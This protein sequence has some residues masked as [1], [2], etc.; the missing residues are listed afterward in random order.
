MKAQM[1]QTL[2]GTRP[3]KVGLAHPQV[4]SNAAHPVISACSNLPPSASPLL[5]HPLIN[6]NPA[7]STNFRLWKVVAK[8]LGGARTRFPPSSGAL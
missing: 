1:G 6:T 2:L 3:P 4:P 8:P 5:G 7:I